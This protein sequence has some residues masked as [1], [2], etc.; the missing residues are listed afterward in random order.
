MFFRLFLIFAIVPVI[1]L[2]LLIKVGTLI[3]TLNTIILVITTA[4]VG[5]YLVRMEGI[6][7]IYRFQQNM[8]EGIF[9][10]EEILDGAMILVA[11]ALLVTPGIL[12]DIIGFSFVFT[13]SRMA[14]KRLLRRYIDKKIATINVRIHRP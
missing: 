4:M 2:S 9:P 11:G 14:I 8:Q 10:A 13:M 7:V 12:T 3:G 1:E 5:S 6:N